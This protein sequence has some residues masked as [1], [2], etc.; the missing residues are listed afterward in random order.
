M[1]H[2]TIK[3]NKKY[4]IASIAMMLVIWQI[5]AMV[6]NKEIIVPSPLQTMK[7]FIEIILAPQFL[8]A[9]AHTLWRV[10]LAFMITIVLALSLGLLSGLIPTLYYVLQ[11][12]VLLFRSVP[13][14]AVILLALIWLRSEKAPV[15]VSLL[16]TFP[17]LYQKE[18]LSHQN[19]DKYPFLE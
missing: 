1:K 10:M 19:D 6:V 9:V 13:T 2:F 11:P 4:V 15:L 8:T 18:E 3:E 12:F 7:V 14:M 17:I 16:V 5:V